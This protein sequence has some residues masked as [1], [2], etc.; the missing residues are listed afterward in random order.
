MSVTADAP[1]AVPEIGFVAPFPG[2]ADLTRF[3]LE[4][5]DDS[6]ALFTLR[7]VED[8]AVR[9]VVA[10]PWTF[11]PDY[12]PEL[13]DEWAQAL[14]LES[15]EDAVLLVVLTL[16]DTLED[17]TANL[18]APIVVHHRTGAAAQIVLSGSDHPLRAPLVGPGPI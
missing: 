15:A 17:S 10:A 13:D 4:P 2:F 7:S 8:E 5:L 1:P 3:A 16:G 14:K 6:G 12:A 18:L 9:L 11:F